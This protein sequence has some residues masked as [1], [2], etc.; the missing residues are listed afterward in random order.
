MPEARKLRSSPDSYGGPAP[1][2]NAKQIA[3]GKEALEKQKAIL[4]ELQE[5]L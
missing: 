5:R 3:L 1:S 2:E 4:A